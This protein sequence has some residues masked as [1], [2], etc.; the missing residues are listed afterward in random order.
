EFAVSRSDLPL[1]RN[2]EIHAEPAVFAQFRQSIT[3]RTR[4]FL[5]PEAAIT[6]VEAAVELP[7][8]EGL[9]RERELFAGL[10]NGEQSQAQRYFFF[11]ERRAAR[12]PGLAA[13]TPVVKV[14]RVAIIG[15]GTMG[16]GIG[17]A[18]ANAGIPVTLVEQ[19]QDFLDRGL[20]VMRTNWQAT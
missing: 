11:A 20:G 14:N 18:F 13:D 9:K 17:M 7:F 3:R 16:G 2:R 1:V 19:Q 10:V 12:I 8:D 6:A 15:A 4:G 5:A